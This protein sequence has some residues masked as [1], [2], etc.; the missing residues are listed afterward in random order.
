MAAN[1]L[2]DDDSTLNRYPTKFQT[3]TLLNY[4]K[5]AHAYHQIVLAHSTEFPWMLPP[6]SSH[7]N[8]SNSFS[9]QNGT[10]CL[11]ISIL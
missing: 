1:L 10:N 7:D 2:L 4:L 11:F 3:I 8:M 5:C 6:S 9:I